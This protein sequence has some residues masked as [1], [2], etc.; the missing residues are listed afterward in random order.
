[1][2]ITYPLPT[3]SPRT[4]RRI[5]FHAGRGE[6]CRKFPYVEGNRISKQNSTNTERELYTWD[7]RNRLTS[8]TQQEFNIET[9]AW[10]TTQTIE[11]TYDYNNVWIRKVVGNDKT[12]FIPENYQ[13]TVQIDDG[14]VTHHYL[15]TPN[16]QDKLLAD[17][18]PSAVLWSLTDHLGTIRD[19]I[20][21]TESGVI[22]Q[23][24]II[25][26]AYG[27]VISCKNSEGENIS[28]PILF[29]YTGKAF[30]VSTQLQNNINRWYDST[31]G[32]WLSTDP[33]GF[34][35]G[36]TNL[37]RYVYNTTLQ[38]VDRFGLDESG[39]MELTELEAK[40]SK[41][42]PLPDDVS[43]I[44]V[45]GG[46]YYDDIYY[47]VKDFFLGHNDQSPH[48]GLA[49]TIHNLFFIRSYDSPI[50]FM[51]NP[52]PPVCW[53][54]YPDTK[55]A[56]MFWDGDRSCSVLR[57]IKNWI[58]DSLK[59]CPCEKPEDTWSNAS[60]GWWDKFY[61]GAIDATNGLLSLSRCCATNPNCIGSYGIQWDCVFECEKN[62]FHLRA[63]IYN[64]FSNPSASY[65]A[66]SYTSRHVYVKIL[67]DVEGFL[68]DDGELII[69]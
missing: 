17:T 30:D 65:E 28:N 59:S 13:T 63:V 18:T 58:K 9:G 6:V 23:A 20:Q 50:Y 10:E 39:V 12:I 61:Y 54:F 44:H 46:S 27:N 31:I 60:N 41:D 67:L 24:H 68:S 2:F 57:Q 3:R 69:F 47:S 22:T 45:H 62:S 49:S 64:D 32:R 37:Y 43:V 11:Y 38:F 55:V 8:V 51:S 1:M 21:S 5:S 4:A 36:D 16:A 48:N 53:I 35:G 25:Y 33:I 66:V 19:I 29:G 26:D 56:K 15:W 34:Y 7:Y 42:Y 52:N 40:M 14:T